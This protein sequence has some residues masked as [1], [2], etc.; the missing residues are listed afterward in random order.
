M[1][2][3]TQMS[4][5]KFIESEGATCKNWQWSWA[6]INHSDKFVIFGAW[7]KNQEGK[8]YVILETK[9]EKSDRGIRPSYPEA[10]EYIRLIE[11]EGYQLKIFLMEHE[12]RDKHDK[13]S[14]AKIAGF[15]Q[16]LMNKRLKRIENKWYACD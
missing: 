12:L 11:E 3:N 13:N 5:R 9:W 2:S 15:T 6:F 16:E 8:E 10:I 4:R 14:P 1:K 7:D